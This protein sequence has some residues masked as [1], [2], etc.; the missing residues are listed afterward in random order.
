MIHY[1]IEVADAAAHLFHV[2][3]TVAAPAA[4][5]ALTLPVWIPGS[6]LVREFSRHLSGLQARQGGAARPLQQVS[7]NRWTVRCEGR[8]PLEVTYQVYAFDASVRTAWLTPDRG[9][10][11]GTSTCLAVEGRM[12]E[13][14]RVEIGELPP[15]WEIATGMRPVGSQRPRAR[16]RTFEAA[17]YDELVDHPF[18]LGPF[19]R[20]RFTV[21]GVPHELVVSGAWPNADT[22]RLLADTQRIVEAQVR[23]WHGDGAP[24]YERYV[25]MLYATE[26]GYG[27]LEHRASTALI[28]A[29]KD[30]PR[31][32]VAGKADGYVTLLGL[33]SHEFFHTW[34]VKRLK[35]ASFLPYDFQQENY[36][37]LLWFFEGFTSY[38][39]DLFLLRTGLIDPARYLKL[40]GR[41]V[42]G[43]AATPGQEVQSVAEASFDAWVKYY[44]ADENTPNATVSYY[45]KGSLV[46]L[47]LDLA[48]R[49]KGRSSLD[50]VMRTLWAEA[51]GGGV[52]EAL[53][54]AVVR[55]LGGKAV[56]DRLHGWVHERAAL[57]VLPA[58]SRV[59]VEPEAEPL[60][61]AQELGLRVSE[62]P[63]TGVQVKT[64]LAGGAAAE[65]G[66][67]SGDEILAVDGLR[68]RR[69]E[70]A[71]GWIAGGAACELLLVRGQ[72]VMSLAVPAR[73]AAERARVAPT[74]LRASAKAPAAVVARRE[75]WLGL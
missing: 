11:N 26:D 3:L 70:D 45:T 1:R 52:D 33:I 34:N 49:E 16:S 60:T 27:G 21:A 8:G 75:A 74:G 41:T 53:V 2:T 23:F 30:L 31:R 54:L 67:S 47:L 29:R 6:Y 44:R 22:A 40:I 12:D 43:V 63:V 55:R 18:E 24:P 35:P 15:G 25:F 64:V 10:F 59:G 7:K 48:L 57:E 68:V 39:D 46:A 42:S 71:A 5:L 50:E 32:G 17:D 51:P 14:H 13:L 9:F 58:L 72:R 61:L 73:D 19:W 56:A 65:A 66:V 36:T 4:D 69:L 37:E 38:Y 28:A 62:G 20:G